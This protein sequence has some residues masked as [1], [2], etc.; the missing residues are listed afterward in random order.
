MGDIVDIVG[1]TDIL[2]NNVR[3]QWFIKAAPADEKHE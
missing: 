3:N 2:A 1:I